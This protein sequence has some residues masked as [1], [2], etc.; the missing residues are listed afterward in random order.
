MSI[1]NMNFDKD[2]FRAHYN[3]LSLVSPDHLRKHS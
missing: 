1:T 2:Q 3:L